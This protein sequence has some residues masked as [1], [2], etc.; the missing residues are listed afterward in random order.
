[1][2]GSAR[3][4]TGRRGCGEPAH[5]INVGAVRAVAGVA[6]RA[7]AAA[8]ASSCLRADY[9]GEAGAGCAKQHW[10]HAQARSA[11]GLHSCGPQKLDHAQRCLPGPAHKMSLTRPGWSRSGPRPSGA[12]VSPRWDWACSCVRPETV[13]SYYP[14]CPWFSRISRAFSP[15]SSPLRCRR[16][17][18][19]LPPAFFPSP[20]PPFRS[21]PYPS[22]GPWLP[23]VLTASITFHHR[24]LQEGDLLDLPGRKSVGPLPMRLLSVP[25][26]LLR[27]P[28][29]EARC[30]QPPPLHLPLHTSVPEPLCLCL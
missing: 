11:C 28:S 8:R 17:P 12:R 3:V 20:F 10:P 30:P 13:R 23:A 7:G 1:M 5:L 9:A 16:R 6:G 22:S 24:I 2:V 14:P 18:L 29:W 19:S 4:G 21:V 27:P 25:L 15:A 26:F